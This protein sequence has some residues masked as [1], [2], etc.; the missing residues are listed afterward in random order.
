MLGVSLRTIQLWVDAGVLTAWRTPG[1][2][3]RIIMG[4]LNQMIRQSTHHKD[5]TIIPPPQILVVEDDENLLSMYKMSMKAWGLDAEMTVA[6]NGF[7]GLM[8]IGKSRPDILI[9][10]LQMPGLDGFDL[11]NSLREAGCDF[12][13]VVATGLPNSQIEERGGLPNNVLL[14]K[15][16][17]NFNLMKEFILEAIKAKDEGIQT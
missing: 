16:P 5:G 17:I 14:L 15:K 2:H 7:E 12:P 3:R 9:L 13:I 11:L 8:Q 6:K 1:G 10:D 4:S